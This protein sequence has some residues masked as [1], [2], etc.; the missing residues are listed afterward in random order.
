MSCSCVCTR[1]QWQNMTCGLPFLRMLLSNMAD[2]CGISNKAN[3]FRSWPIYLSYPLV[4]WV[5]LTRVS[6]NN[7][8]CMLTALS[9]GIPAKCLHE[10]VGLHTLH[11]TADLP[12]QPISCR[13]KPGNGCCGILT[14]KWIKS[15]IITISLELLFIWVYRR[16][17]L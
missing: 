17:S 10:C 5:L 14:K 11:F 6:L 13:C 4:R 3:N 2:Q 9:L 12:V 15:T 1:L 7:M 16:H 8:Y